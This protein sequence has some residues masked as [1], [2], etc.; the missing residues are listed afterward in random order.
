MALVST[1]ST[2]RFSSPLNTSQRVSLVGGPACAPVVHRPSGR[3]Q[4]CRSE[5]CSYC[6]S[7]SKGHLTRDY[8]ELPQRHRRRPAT[9]QP[10]AMPRLE[11]GTAFNHA[12]CAGRK[13]TVVRNGTCRDTPVMVHR[14]RAQTSDGTLC[15]NRVRLADTVAT[16][17]KVDRAGEQLPLG[18]NGPWHRHRAARLVPHRARGARGPAPAGRRHG[19]LRAEP[20]WIGA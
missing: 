3:P 20:T 2:L 7:T 1:R 5:A 13:G 15:R 11:L 14:C 6:T 8:S 16:S 9:V 4:T 19:V 10:A 18:G 17:I 12:P